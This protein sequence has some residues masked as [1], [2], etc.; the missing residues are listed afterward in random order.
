[1]PVVDGG[2]LSLTRQQWMKT[3]WKTELNQPSA[4]LRDG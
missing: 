3:S 2:K 4:D 1:M